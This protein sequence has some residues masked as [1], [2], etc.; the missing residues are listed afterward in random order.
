MPHK[1]MTKEEKHWQAE[2]DAHTLANAQEIQKDK[3][4]MGAAKKVAGEQAKELQQR[5]T[6]MRN[7]AQR[8]TPTA[9]NPVRKTTK[10]TTA[11]KA[12]KNPARRKR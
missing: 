4:R 8:K 1:R 3:G 10:K 2:S 7:I 5:T 9:P 6:A 12:A 11:R